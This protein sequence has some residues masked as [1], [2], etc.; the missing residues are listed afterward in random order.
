MPP[1]IATYLVAYLWHSVYHVHHGPGSGSSWLRG[2]HRCADPLRT[3]I[4]M[5]SPN[6]Q[7]EYDFIGLLEHTSHLHRS[8][9][10]PK[11]NYDK[12]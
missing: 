9:S 8:A 7:N 11:P 1:L 5:F 10:T 3:S 2:F 4:D 12:T 6:Q